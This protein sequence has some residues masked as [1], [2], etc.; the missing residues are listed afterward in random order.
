MLLNRFDLMVRVLPIRYGHW[1]GVLAGIRTR[2]AS[3]AD[4][5]STN[6]SLSHK[7]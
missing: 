5:H 3:V 2:A 1:P 6:S 4:E 7:F